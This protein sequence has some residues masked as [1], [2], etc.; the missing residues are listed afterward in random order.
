MDAH[1]ARI[2]RDARPRAPALRHLP[3][4]P[5]ARPGARPGDLQAPLRA[6]RRQPPG[7]RARDRPRAGDLAE[8]RLRGRHAG[9]AGRAS[10][11]PTRRSTTAPSRGCGC[12]TGPSGRCSSTPRRR[13]G[14]TTRATPW[15]RSSSAPP[16]RRG[17]PRSAAPRRPAQDRRD[18]LRA[19]RHRPG[20]RVRLLRRAGPARA[21]R[22]GLRDR[23]R[24]LQP[25]DDHD[26]PGLGR[27]DVH[28]AARPGGRVQ[29]AAPRAARRAAADARRP[30]RAQHGHGA[31]TAPGCWTSSGSS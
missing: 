28:R 29:R 12:P 19:D 3:R 16:R 6:P 26:R 30:D 11:S 22:G 21:A 31:W 5:A 9:R 24:Q 18:R 4:P 17:G 10:R 7:A 27:P 20:L 13:P 1:V 2:A 14:R 23:P 25:G 15:W 8:P